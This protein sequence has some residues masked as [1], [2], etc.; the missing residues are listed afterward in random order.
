NLADNAFYFGLDG[1]T[2]K[3]EAVYT[4]FGDIVVKSYPELISSYPP[5]DEVLDLSYLT[6]VYS[7]N[8][9]NSDMT[10]A[11]TPI[12]KEGE[13]MSQL[14]SS[15]SVTIEFKTGSAEISSV[16]AATLEQLAK[17]LIIAEGL[18][19]EINGHTDSQG[20]D[21]LNQT[22]SEARAN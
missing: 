14:V 8:K 10:A 9:N 6:A 7:Q 18:L 5:I 12:F 3:Y 15:K 13:T 20:D 2:N 11:S 17:D 1:G 22:L 16:S 19:V 4:T 21:M